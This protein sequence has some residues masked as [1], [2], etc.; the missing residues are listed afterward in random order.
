MTPARPE[1]A[2]HETSKSKGSGPHHGHRWTLTGHAGDPTPDGMQHLLARG[3]L[4]EAAVRDASAA[5][6]SSTWAIRGRHRTHEDHDPRLQ[7]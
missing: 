7:Y 4:D 3:G 2:A 1:L 5:G 6:W